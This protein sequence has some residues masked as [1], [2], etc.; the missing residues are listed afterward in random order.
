MIA[1]GRALF[2]LFVLGE[3][4]TQVGHARFGAAVRLFALPPG[5]LLP[6]HRHTGSIS[7]EVELGN[8]L[9]FRQRLEGLTLL[10]G[11]GIGSDGLHQALNLA[12]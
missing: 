10:P 2:V 6:P 9:S 8:R 11:L 7:T 12:R 5:Q 1:N 4:T 3:D